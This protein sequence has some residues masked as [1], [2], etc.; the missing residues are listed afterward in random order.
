MESYEQAVELSLMVVNLDKSIYKTMIRGGLK[1]YLNSVYP[2]VAKLNNEHELNKFVLASKILLNDLQAIPVNSCGGRTCSSCM[3]NK[4]DSSVEYQTPV[5]E[6]ALIDPLNVV[7]SDVTRYIDGYNPNTFNPQ[8]SRLSQPLDTIGLY[9]NK[10]HEP[11]MNYGSLTGYGP[12]DIQNKYLRQQPQGSNGPSAKVRLE[13]NFQNP[14]THPI[15]DTKNTLYSQYSS[16]Y[17]NDNGEGYYQNEMVNQ[18][19]EQK[20]VIQKKYQQIHKN[21]FVQ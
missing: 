19:N 18:V 6:E 11:M 8:I 12:S 3:M 2:Y 7:N 14:T 5:F 10:L 9:Q 15:P 17:V 1:Q 13:E 20:P 4:C 21:K 16:V